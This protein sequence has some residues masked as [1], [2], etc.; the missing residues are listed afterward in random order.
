MTAPLAP[1]QADQP[2]LNRPAGTAYP[3]NVRR[4]DH[5]QPGVPGGAPA[6][7]KTTGVP[8]YEHLGAIGW[9]RP[10]P[11]YPAQAKILHITGSGSVRCVTDSSG[12]VVS[13]VIVESAGSPILDHSMMS[14]AKAN[15][16]GPP[17]STAVIPFTYRFLN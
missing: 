2:K 13:A 9:H 11:P 6:A 1:K 10:E 4:G 5:P 16:S 8:G 14:F 3:V 15:W 17:N 7:E 12:R